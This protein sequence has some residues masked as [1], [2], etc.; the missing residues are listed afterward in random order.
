MSLFTLMAS[1]QVVDTSAAGVPVYLSTAQDTF[2][3]EFNVFAGIQVNG[4]DSAIVWIDAPTQEMVTTAASVTLPTNI[5]TVILELSDSMKLQL[6]VSEYSSAGLLPQVKGGLYLGMQT[7]LLNDGAAYTHFRDNEEYRYT[8]RFEQRRSHLYTPNLKDARRNSFDR[9]G[10]LFSLHLWDE[11]T[12]SFVT[13]YLENTGDAMAGHTPPG[14]HDG[15]TASTGE[16]DV[17]TYNAA[18]DSYQHHVYQGGTGAQPLVGSSVVFDTLMTDEGRGYAVYY[19]DNT[20]AWQSGLYS[21]D[22]INSN[23]GFI[24]GDVDVDIT[25]S[26]LVNGVFKGW[27]M[28]GNPYKEP[29]S[30]LA[31]INANHPFTGSDSNKSTLGYFGDGTISIFTDVRTTEAGFQGGYVQVNK[32]GVPVG[33]NNFVLDNSPSVAL[34]NFSTH[35]DSVDLAGNIDKIAPGQAFFVYHSTPSGTAVTAEFRNNMRVND[36]LFLLKEQN[37][38]ETEIMVYLDVLKTNDTAISHVNMGQLGFTISD[39]V[40]PEDFDI[41][42]F[43]QDLSEYNERILKTR[44]VNIYTQNNHEDPYG[45]SLKALSHKMVNKLI[46]LGF[47]SKDDKGEYSFFL[48]RNMNNEKYDIYIVDRYLNIEAKVSDN[49]VYKFNTYKNSSQQNRFFLKFKHKEDDTISKEPNIY[50]DN[51]SIFVDIESQNTMIESIEVYDVLGRVVRNSRPEAYGSFDMNVST[52]KTGA[53]FVKVKA[54]GEMF[55]QKI[56][57]K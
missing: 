23:F 14:T 33:F 16:N 18:N 22:S 15:S 32:M 5:D 31:F 39:D 34:Q 9:G 36:D 26:S 30:T 21:L 2:Y 53:Y 19:G 51:N 20:S 46:P 54:G 4:H 44:N 38:F 29:I 48:S 50:F 56:I 25:N 6:D 28:L 41:R 42:T 35:T 11:K 43:R 57:K 7:E 45:N 24:D 40:A 37:F 1:A 10:S 47:E 55:S 52:L 3:S 27:H 13:G 17:T 8:E 12:E 49:N